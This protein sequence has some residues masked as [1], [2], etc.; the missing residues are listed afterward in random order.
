[1]S[2]ENA[3]DVSA[4]IDSSSRTGPQERRCSS[5]DCRRGAWDFC[6]FRKLQCI[7]MSDP[8]TTAERSSLMGS[9]QPSKAYSFV[10]ARAFDRGVGGRVSDIV[11]ASG[12]ART[13]IWSGGSPAAPAFAV[14]SGRSSG[15]AVDALH[16]V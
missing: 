16:L 15:G 9:P 3:Q 7:V 5:C 1:M 4:K 13:E 2:Y 6:P 10:S 11:S 8:A 14:F 12:Y